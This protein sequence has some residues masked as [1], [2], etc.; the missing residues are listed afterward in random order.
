MTNG[1]G[2]TPSMFVVELARLRKNHPNVRMS[3]INAITVGELLHHLTGA[4]LVE[5]MEEIKRAV[6]AEPCQ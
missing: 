1:P 2:V 6:E 3:T 5:A 4:Q